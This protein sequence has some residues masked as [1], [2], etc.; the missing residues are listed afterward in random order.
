MPR[1]AGLIVLFVSAVL[2]WLGFS[3][4]RP[5]VALYFNDAGYSFAIIGLLMALHAFIPVLL[6]MPA[7]LL[8]DRIGPRRSVFI[9]SMIM[10][11]S[12]LCYLWGSISGLLFPV[13]IGQLSNGLG[14]LL[15]WGAMQA[16][17]GQIA[18]GDNDK[19]GNHMLANFAFVNALAQFGGPIIGGML[20]DYSSFTLVFIIFTAGACLCACFAY[21][22]PDT[23]SAQNDTKAGGHFQ[24]L[25]S[26]VSGFGLLKQNRM[27]STALLFNGVLFILVDVQT[28]FL[29]IYLANMEYSATQIGV[30]LSF[31][32]I[33]SIVIR[34]LTGGMLNLLGHR[35]MLHGSIWLGSSCLLLLLLEPS[36]WALASIVFIWGLCTGVNQPIALIMV[37]R[38]VSGNQ[39][40][41]G[42]S[43]RT[44]ANR[45]IQ[46]VNPVALGGLSA[47]IGITYSFGFIAI[48]LM[49]FSIF[50]KKSQG[51]EVKEMQ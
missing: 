37:A 50:M 9:G 14:S 11:G 40:G 21:L 31:G 24:F 19:R 4:L 20:A 39:Q 47:V 32:G 22:L 43:L 12:G 8:I 29:P 26:Y 16:S 42:M 46:V 27:F 44:M 7:G 15:S 38:T 23:R 45:I 1:S 2:Y 34:P 48:L 49:G 13:L 51:T 17:A 30:L 41:M 25:G 28:T 3:M 36:Y 6:A 5:M 33:A 18:R 35:V 10:V